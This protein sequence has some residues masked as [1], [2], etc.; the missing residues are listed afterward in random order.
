FVAGFVALLLLAALA[1]RQWRR[2]DCSA[3]ASLGFGLVQAG[4]T[5]AVVLGVY[6]FA[7]IRLGMPVVEAVVLAVIVE[8]A[9]WVAVGLV[10]SHARKGGVGFGPGGP[11]F[12]VAVLGGGTL[13][14]AGSTSAATAVGRAVIVAL[15]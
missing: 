2:R 10:A 7:A 15:G 6:E 11:F 12:W 5:Y 14:V 3:K 8:A 4:V 1:V 13:A 9:T